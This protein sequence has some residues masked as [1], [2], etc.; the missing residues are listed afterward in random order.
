MR[1][2]GFTLRLSGAFA[3]TR[4]QKEAA[5]ALRGDQQSSAPR[6][7]DEDCREWLDFH[8]KNVLASQLLIVLSLP[9][10]HEEFYGNESV[11]VNAY[12]SAFPREHQ[13]FTLSDLVI[14]GD[15]VRPEVVF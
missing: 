1:P 5:I 12:D 4:E 14:R 2:A 10:E 11:R 9:A 8:R 13:R 6:V 15:E 3:H 7:T